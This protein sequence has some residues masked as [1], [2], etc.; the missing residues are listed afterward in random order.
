L[1]WM[2]GVLSDAFAIDFRETISIFVLAS[3]D[4]SSPSP[5]VQNAEVCSCP[6]IV[7]TCSTKI[8]DRISRSSLSL[9]ML[10]VSTADNIDVAFPPDTLYYTC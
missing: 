9:F 4:K 7:Q 1:H 8:F 6:S 5:S 3:I 10:R 2:V